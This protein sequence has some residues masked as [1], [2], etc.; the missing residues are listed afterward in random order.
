MSA[1]RSR[2]A[3]R[4]VA[5][6]VLLVLTLTAFGTTWLAANGESPCGWGIFYPP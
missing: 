5:G 6:L 4:T 1:L 3:R 2:D